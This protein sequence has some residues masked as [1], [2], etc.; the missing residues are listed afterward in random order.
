MSRLNTAGSDASTPPRADLLNVALRLL[1]AAGLAYS[2]YV[3]WHLHAQYAANR[4]SALSQ[5]D[6]FV[7]QAATCGV[8]AVLVVLSVRAA[9]RL[10][11]A[12]WLLAAAVAAGSLLA[13]LAYRYIDIGR[14]GPLPDMYEPVW[15]G[16]KTRSAVAEAVA[17]VAS[18]VGLV[19]LLIE[20]RRR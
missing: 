12:G 2:A 6:V 9:R 7:V 15:Y 11:L 14:V 5:S 1:T 17:A 20:P 13:V 4:T 16:L 3:H 8:V 18:G 10:Q 19:R